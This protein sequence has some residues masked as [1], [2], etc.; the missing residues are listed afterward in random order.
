M[1][2]VSPLCAGA[3]GVAEFRLWARG[4]GENGSGR[5]SSRRRLAFV[6]GCEGNPT[7]R[8]AVRLAHSRG[9]ERSEVCEREN[10]DR[11]EKEL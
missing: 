9:G 3:R 7:C 2:I 11:N 8:Q 1:A 4:R 6:R 5:P 10:R